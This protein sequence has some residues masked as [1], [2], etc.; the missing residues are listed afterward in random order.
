MDYEEV[1]PDELHD[2]PT[3]PTPT[4]VTAPNAIIELD[5][6]VDPPEDPGESAPSLPHDRLSI[7]ADY[8]QALGFDTT[9][10]EIE[11]IRRTHAEDPETVY[12]Y[13]ADHLTELMLDLALVKSYTKYDEKIEEIVD[14]GYEIANAIGEFTRLVEKSSEA[15]LAAWITDVDP[16]TLDVPDTY[17]E[18]VE[19]ADGDGHYI[20]PISVILYRQTL[21]CWMDAD[22]E[23]P[24]PHATY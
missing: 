7:L 4:A 22:V 13:T 8:C 19:I 23:L 20:D 16:S 24:N 15:P 6:H 2:E 17:C 18:H 12:R 11:I 10:A 14:D 5:A 9:S 21:E 3:D 1:D